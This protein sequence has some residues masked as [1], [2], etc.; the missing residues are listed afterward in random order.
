MHLEEGSYARNAQIDNALSGSVSITSDELKLK[1]KSFVSTE[2]VQL[3][4]TNYSNKTETDQNGSVDITSKVFEIHDS[5]YV[6]TTTVIPMRNAGDI[7]IDTGSLE[8]S[9]NSSL[10]SNTEPNAYD[11]E[12]GIK[13]SAYSDAGSL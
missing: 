6:K 4:Q 5:S 11:I 1:G 10:L 8:L 3:F 9:G 2:T 13:D 12:Q 7:T